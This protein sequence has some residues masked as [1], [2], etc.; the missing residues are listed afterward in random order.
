[1]HFQL[2]PADQVKMVYCVVG[3]VLDVI[4]DLRVGAPTFGR[5][6]TRELSA[7]EHNAVYLPSGIAHG[8]YVLEAPALV[9]YNVTSEHAPALDSGVRWDSF[10]MRWPSDAPI[11][12]DRDSRLPTLD[13]FRSPFKHHGIETV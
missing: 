13:Q 6:V 8:F 10:G 7:A 11:V 12:S 9:I 1:M 5:H 3:R 4:L 2:P